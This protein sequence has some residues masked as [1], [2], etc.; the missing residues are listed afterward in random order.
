MTEVEHSSGALTRVFARGVATASLVVGFV[1]LLLIAAARPASAQSGDT[2][3]ASADKTWDTNTLV[4]EAHNLTTAALEQVRARANGGDPRSQV[5]MGLVY[6]M[7]AVGLKSDPVQALAWFNKAAAQGNPWA[8]TWAGDFYF[9]G[10]PGV[11][12]DLYK[13]SELY[14]SA[15]LHGDHKGAFYVGRMYFFGE[16]VA[17]NMAEA[18]KWF[19]LAEPADPELVQ[20]MIA[21][22]EGTC[23]TS[24]CIALRQVM[25]AMATESADQFTGD[26][27][28]ETHEWDSVKT[29]PDFERCGFT[30]SNRTEEGNVQNFFCD[31]DV[32]TDAAEGAAAARRMADAV[33]Q[34]LSAGWMRGGGTDP[35]PNLYFFSR[36]GFPRVRVSYNTTLG[37][38]AQ[39]LTLL[40]GP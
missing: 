13:A 7:G 24:F 17:M 31:S 1:A 23:G 29:L 33:A 30:S 34:A 28:D 21:L 10:S 5:L 18:A 22:A 19:R 40:V 32:I 4:N 20:R 9:T 14:K 3:A 25:G 36:E 6:E 26:W 15:A 16:G 38:A 37:A 39:R 2:V 8:E 35:R 27:D 12:R 11:P